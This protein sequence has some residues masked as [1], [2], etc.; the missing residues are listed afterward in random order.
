MIIEFFRA[1]W[2]ILVPAFIAILGIVVG[3]WIYRRGKS[4]KKVKEEEKFKNDVRERLAKLEEAKNMLTTLYPQLKS[5]ERLKDSEKLNLTRE[6]I[7]KT[8]SEILKTTNI[9]PEAIDVRIE[10]KVKESF[11]D[12]DK[13]IAAIVAQRLDEIDKRFKKPIGNASDY[14]KLGNAEY[15][16][17]N[18]QRAIEHY[19]KAIEIKPDD[20][21]AWHN[22]GV[23]L[24]ELGRYEDALKAYDKAIE[25]EPDYATA[26][27][28]KGIA[29]GKLGRYD[30]ALKA[31]NKAIEIKPDYTK[32]WYNKACVY[33][34]ND[35]KENA[36]K[37]LSKAIELD[38]KDKE[39]AKK[40]EDFKNLWYDED[41]KKIVS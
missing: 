22:K 25:I 7:S 6:D 27:H 17:R 39:K 11:S 23:A 40:D 38:Q 15:D 30:D 37:N 21:M 4:E 3:Y 12:V 9:T 18:Y 2:G 16:E 13:R 32:A 33:S 26:W 35:N 24:G 8:V 14:L 29:L 20:A 36:L 10:E 1:N 5:L 28:N 31:Y 41:F 19:D 34:L